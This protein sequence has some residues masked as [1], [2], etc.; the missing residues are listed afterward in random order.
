MRISTAWLGEARGG[1][2]QPDCLRSADRRTLRNAWGPRCRTAGFQI[3]ANK[4]GTCCRK[5]A[6]T[7][8]VAGRGSS[9]LLHHVIDPSYEGDAECRWRAGSEGRADPQIARIGDVAGAGR[10]SQPIGCVVDRCGHSRLVLNEVD[11]LGVEPGAGRE[12]G[13]PSP[14]DAA[15]R[16]TS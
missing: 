16:N 10:K 2:R 8:G 9:P 11:G 5:G 6:R 14:V 3:I 12:C 4:R 1:R 13:R 15:D 7:A